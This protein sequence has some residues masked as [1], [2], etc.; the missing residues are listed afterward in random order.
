ME[1]QLVR[2]IV[3]LNVFPGEDNC[4]DET[5]EGNRNA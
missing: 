4:S 5:R 1:V 3:P 2:S